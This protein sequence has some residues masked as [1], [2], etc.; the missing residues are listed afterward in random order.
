MLEAIKRRTRARAHH[1]DFCD[2]CGCVCDA[3]DLARSLRD[4]QRARALS[5]WPRA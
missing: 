4:A 3:R 5:I 2:A 1:I